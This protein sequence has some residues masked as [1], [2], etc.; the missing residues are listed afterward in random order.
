MTTLTLDRHNGHAFSYDVALPGYNYRID[1]MR[2]ALG[3]VQLGRLAERTRLD[4]RD[5]RPLPRGL[6]GSRVGV[7]VRIGS[8]RLVAGESHTTSPSI[9]LPRRVRSAERVPSELSTNA[10][11]RRASTTRRSIS[12][13]RTGSAREGRC[14]S[15]DA[16]AGR[17]LTLPLYGR[18]TDE[19]VDSVIEG[20]V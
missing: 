14:R 3:V 7:V 16:L 5:R 19:Q 9:V 6:D 1:E 18:L 17:I 13:P 10:G 20:A 4:G 11:S 12:S 8:E 2:S 15:T